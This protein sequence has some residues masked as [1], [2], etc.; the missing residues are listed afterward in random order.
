MDRDHIRSIV[1]EIRTYH[2]ATQFVRDNIMGT[3]K[4]LVPNGATKEQCFLIR[5]FQ[6]ELMWYLTTPPAA[7]GE[8]WRGHPI[9][10]ICTSSGL[11]VCICFYEPARKVNTVNLG[12]K[13]YWTERVA[14]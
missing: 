14:Q 3:V 7:S 6:K 13:N 10:W 11:W 8:C 9:H 12:L 5:R 1:A 2:P 4:V